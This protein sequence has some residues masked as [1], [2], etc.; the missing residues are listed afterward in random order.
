MKAKKDQLANYKEKRNFDQ[1]PEPPGKTAGKGGSLVFV[2]QKHRARNLHYDFRLELDG[3]LKSWAVPKGLSMDPAQKRL[4]IQVEDHPL[5]YAKFEGKIPAGQYGAGEVEIWDSGIWEPLD[6]PHKGR[7]KGHMKFRLK[8]ERFQGDWALVRMKNK[9]DSKKEQ[10][11]LIKEKDRHAIPEGAKAADLPEHMAPQLAT[12][13]KSP[14]EGDDWSYEIKFDGYRILARIDGENVKLF[15]RNGKDWTDKLGSLADEVRGLGISS[16]WLDG[17]IVVLGKEGTPD[18]GA[19]QNAFEKA[20]TGEVL[21]FVFDL[22]FYGGYDLRDA[23]HADRKALL[24]SVIEHGS[25]PSRIRISEGFGP[26]GRDVLVGACGRGMEGVIGKRAGS[27]YVSERS[28]DWIKIK[29]KNRQE[30]IILGYTD[31]KSGSEYI[32]ALLLGVLDESGQMRYAGKVGTGF[33]RKAAAMLKEKLS[34]IETKKNIQLIHTT[35]VNPHFVRPEL[36]AEISFAE[37][38]RDGKVRQAVFHG[39]RSDKPP[40]FIKKESVATEISN[41]DRIVDPSTGFKKIDVVDY[42]ILAA[43]RMMPHLRARPVAF[44]RAPS[45]IAGDMFFQKHDKT[46]TIPGIRQLDTEFDPSHQPLIEIDSTEAL[47]GAAQMNVL[48]FHVWN[49]NTRNI[50][51]PDRMVF[52]LDPGE[53]LPWSRMIEAAR[54]VKT[55]LEELG[56]VSFLKT[57]G[58]K[59]LHILVPLTSRD[60]WDLV[61]EFA[62]AVSEHLAKTLPEIFTAVSGP[63][64]R[65]GRIFVDY[66]RNTRGATTVAAYSVRGRPG[67]GVSI[68]CDWAELP[69]LK[70]GDHWNIVTAEQRLKSDKDPW[71]NFFR[72]KQTLKVAGKKKLGL[73]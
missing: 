49:A 12:L 37:W 54:L 1:S 25:S 4:A 45:G 22:P 9:E 53:G 24:E 19:L 61:K 23:V 10:W 33:D 57:S 65:V 31:S 51:K 15:T 71:E 6:D 41:P 5:E 67:L 60:D 39:L 43:E 46:L 56:L 72:T 38:T 52:D 27:K 64:N 36:V 32:G 58:G 29:C 17:E 16:G 70:S 44:L 20:A 47:I 8:G 42:Y 48:E 30:L 7:E 62:K 59:G 35:E 63:R 28:K 11:L 55:L 26:Q 21:Y 73:R 2:V 13:V 50:E 3:V 14:P 18:F 68:P 66:L 34:G 69:D 40:A